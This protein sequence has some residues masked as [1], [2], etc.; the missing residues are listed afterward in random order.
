MAEVKDE[1]TA[2]FDLL[3][4]RAKQEATKA[5][6]QEQE[7]LQRRFASLGQGSSGAA[8]RS[9]SLA[10]SRGAERLQQAQ[11]GIGFQEA[12]E[13]QRQ[14]EI[15]KQREF[16]TSEREAGQQFALGAQ[17]GQQEF[18]AQQAELAR[19]YATGERKAGQEFAIGERQAGQTF[20]TE[21]NQLSRALQQAGLDL[22]TEAQN[23]QIAQF[24]REFN[25]DSNT[26]A[27][28]QK[29]AE[30]ASKSNFLDDLGITQAF[31]NIYGGAIN[32]VKSLF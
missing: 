22:Q 5:T 21:Q 25:R 30:S 9:Q 16:Q 7:G 13:R 15:A 20:A 3:R 6:Q 28:N 4:K 1:T 32:K 24:E 18:G 26:I 17:K 31:G 19:Q 14:G 12:A 11:E 2:Q 27:F 10:E 8:I 29:M 23:T